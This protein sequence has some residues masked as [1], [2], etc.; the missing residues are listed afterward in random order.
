MAKEG[1]GLRVDLLVETEDKFELYKITKSVEH[2]HELSDPGP[3]ESNGE[4]N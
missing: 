2:S 4:L 1:I 3:G